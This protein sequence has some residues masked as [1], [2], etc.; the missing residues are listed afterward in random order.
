MCRSLQK[1]YITCTHDLLHYYLVVALKTFKG[2]SRGI[3]NGVS[4]NISESRAKV[5]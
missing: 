1:Q 2:F 3:V 5:N 4:A